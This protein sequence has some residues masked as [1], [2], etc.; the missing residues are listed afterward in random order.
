MKK[1]ISAT[2]DRKLIDWIN[3]QLKDNLKYRNKSHLVEVAIRTLKKE[4]ESK[5]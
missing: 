2:I 5:R 4:E 3:S 1:P